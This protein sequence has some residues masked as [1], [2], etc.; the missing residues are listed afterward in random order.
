MCNYLAK[1]CCS[2]LCIINGINLNFLHIC[3]SRVIL[4]FFVDAWAVALTMPCPRTGYFPAG[5][6]LTDHHHHRQVTPTAMPISGRI[7]DNALDAV[8]NTPLIRLDKVAEL[9]GLKCNLRE[10]QFMSICCSA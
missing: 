8:G 3:A 1:A 4:C 2:L 7:L 10:W 6:S 9:E 5:T